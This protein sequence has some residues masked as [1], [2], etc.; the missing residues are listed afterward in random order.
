MLRP[1]L[2]PRALADAYH[3]LDLVTRRLLTELADSC[4]DLWRNRDSGIWELEQQEH[5]TMSKI[6]C[7]TALNQAVNL[8]ANGQI[9][10]S[11]SDRW[12]RERDRIRAWIDKHCWSE[13]KQSYTM[14]PDTVVLD[15]SI[16]LAT[17]FGFERS[18]RLALTRDAVK[19]ELCRGPLVYRYSGMETE[20][21]TFIACGFWLVEAFALLGDKPSAIA[22]MDAMLAACNKNLGLLNEQIDA[23][24]GAMLG[25]MPQALSHL[26]LIH[27]ASSIADC[28]PQ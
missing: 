22:Q 14:Y 12:K 25:N 7:W 5:Y 15:A 1:K 9:D 28:V 16:L 24:T 18:D 3:I 23:K 19:Q 4:A 2:K 20:E 11:H 26:A 10:G 27:A 6:G 13:S 17:R 21:G 8:A